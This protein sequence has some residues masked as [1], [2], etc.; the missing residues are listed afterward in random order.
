[1]LFYGYDVTVIWI[2][3][4]TLF[5]DNSTRLHL[6]EFIMIVKYYVWLFANFEIKLGIASSN[7]L[8]LLRFCLT[9][10]EID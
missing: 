9:L 10:T 4:T 2:N 5:Y 3:K 1:M 8:A 7:S 6:I